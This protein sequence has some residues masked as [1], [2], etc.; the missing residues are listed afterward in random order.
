[1]QKDKSK[2]LPLLFA[3]LANVIFG[4]SFLF[5]KIVLTVAVPS[6]VVALRF[7]VAFFILNCILLTG[8]VKVNLKGKN[9]KL[10]LLLGVFHP[11]M[12]F[13]CE[14]YGLKFS[15][16]SFAGT[17]MAL[18]PIACL[19]FGTIFLKEKARRFQIFCALISVVGVFLTT[20]GQKSGSF[21]L[22]G[23]VLLLG[24]VISGSMFMVLSRKISEE[25]S[26]FERTYVMFALGSIT[27]VS[28][29]LIQCKDNIQGMLLAP[30]TNLNFCLSII[31]LAVFCSIGAFMLL[32]Y[33]T[34]YLDVAK[35]S[36]FANITTVISILAGVIILNEKFGFYQI[37]GSVI[38]ILSVYGVN[39]PAKT[40]KSQSIELE[41]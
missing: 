16:T 11:I 26:A 2:G 7:T 8:K 24:A 14:S 5:S 27:F 37:L 6:V 19:I 3:F 1:M 23:F 10:L 15:A 32:N 17:M 21:N 22:I 36:I 13:I 34:T 12:Y 31:F 33:A 30:I 40:V 9:I 28:I 39:R 4:F 41:E 29:A 35:T 18:I 38:I 25:F 20:F